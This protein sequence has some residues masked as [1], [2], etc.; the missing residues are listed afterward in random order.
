ML[1]K[2]LEHIIA[3]LYKAKYYALILDCTPD[4]S[5]SEKIPFTIRFVAEEG[6]CIQVKEHFIEF[7]TVEE[8]SGESLT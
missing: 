4:V 2:V 7:K 3:G 1:M 6:G 5:H 8:S